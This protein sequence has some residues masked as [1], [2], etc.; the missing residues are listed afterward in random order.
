MGCETGVG[1]EMRVMGR[2]VHRLDCSGAPLHTSDGASVYFFSGNEEASSEAA[3]TMRDIAAVSSPCFN[4]KG[5]KEVSGATYRWLKDCAGINPE[6][7][8]MLE[9]W[10]EEFDEFGNVLPAVAK[11]NSDDDCYGCADPDGGQCEDA[12]SIVELICVE[13]CSGGP[14]GLFMRA[15]RKVTALELQ[16]A[17]RVGGNNLANLGGDIAAQPEPNYGWGEGPGDMVRAYDENGDPG[18]NPV[19]DLVPWPDEETIPEIIRKCSC[20]SRY[21]GCAIDAADVLADPDLDIPIITGVA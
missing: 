21:N 15:V 20:A 16:Q 7:R 1:Y 10:T 17:W 8:A 18:C 5:Y 2:F 4:R 11:P 19:V 14:A 9:G 3:P 6:F 12:W 13:D